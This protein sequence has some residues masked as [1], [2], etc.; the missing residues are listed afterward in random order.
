V[1]NIPPSPSQPSPPTL[2]IL[3]HRSSPAATAS[4]ALQGRDF[5]AETDNDVESPTLE[6]R[7]EPTR[8]ASGGSSEG[9][10]EACSTQACLD[11]LHGMEAGCQTPP[12]STKTLRF[13]CSPIDLLESGSSVCGRS[14]L[15]GGTHSRA[16]YRP[17]QAG[18]FSPMPPLMAEMSPIPCKGGTPGRSCSPSRS[19]EV[20]PARVESPPTM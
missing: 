14:P 19:R 10:E 7:E 5:G 17:S 1:P 16:A 2:E 20:P 13:A 4:P 18:C 12:P 6:G 11:S 15:S 8:V 3:T 9:S